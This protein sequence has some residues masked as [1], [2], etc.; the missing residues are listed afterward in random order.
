[1]KWPIGLLIAAISLGGARLAKSSISSARRDEVAEPYTPSPASAPF[2]SL[3]YREAFA[4]VLFVRLIGYFS[5]EHSRGPA[6]AS[7]AETIATLNPRF[8]RIYEMGA[9]AMTIARHDVDQST[10]L[11]AI[12]LLERGMKEFP[13]DWHL[14]YLAG[15][16]YTQDLQTDDANQ[17]REWDERGALLIESAVRKPGAPQ[18]AA[19]WAAVMRTKLGQH[20]RAA[21]SLRE[22]ILITNNAEARQ[23][24]I[25]QLAKLEDQDADV[26]RAELGA[27][28]IQ[29]LKAWKR[30]RRWLPATFYVLLGKRLELGFDL[31]DLATGGRDL[32]GTE[33]QREGELEPLE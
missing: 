14:P 17:R 3:G 15:Q 2:V 8:A 24:M 20:E 21:Q 10:Y 23:R 25:D 9:N 33:L 13:G 5:D 12:D 29:F 11:R 30:D 19:A 18:Q 31:D 28:R 32:I 7:L 27:Q 22:M 4:D 1:M 16:I 6:V 26:L